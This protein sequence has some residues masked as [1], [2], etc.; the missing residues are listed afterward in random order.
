MSNLPFNPPTESF[1]LIILGLIY[2]ILLLPIQLLLVVPYPLLLPSCISKLFLVLFTHIKYS[3]ILRA[4]SFWIVCFGQLLSA[5]SGLY[6][7]SFSAVSFFSL[8]HYCWKFFRLKLNLRICMSLAK[9]PTCWSQLSAAP[10]N[11]GFLGLTAL[12]SGDSG[13]RAPM[14]AAHPQRCYPFHSVPRTAQATSL[15][16]PFPSMFISH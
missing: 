3:F 4:W 1:I 13:C 16:L 15:A 14:R 7:L 5:G 12:V 11:L 10:A 2:R 6:S 9:S 8:E